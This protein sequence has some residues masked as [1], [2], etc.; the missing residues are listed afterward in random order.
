[1]TI[2]FSKTS[3]LYAGLLAITT[4]GSHAADHAAKA[5][6][7]HN[8]HG[9]KH[10]SYS[11]EGAPAQWGY[12]EPGFS[13]CRLGKQQSPVDIRVQGSGKPAPIDFAYTASSAEVVNNGHTVQI[14]LPDAGGFK[15]DGTEFKLAQFHFHTPSEEKI[16]GVA[17][18]MV[19]HLVHKSAAGNLA[20]VAVLF[21]L[22]DENQALK[23][24]FAKLPANG[25]TAHLSKAFNVSDLLPAYKGYYKFMGSLTTP[26]CTENVQWQ[27]LKQRV[28]IS[29]AQWEAF[30]K[31]YKMN[32][33][34]VQPLNQRQVEES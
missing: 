26:P 33:R 23:E 30:R 11:G 34:P 24:M 29:K 14:N 5:I 25:Q 6:D 16:R 22:G 32:A 3:L 1:M 12:L 27:I 8:A 10:W 4:L 19:A 15:L 2:C 7:Q 9:A 17:Y 13:L 31:L 28:E 18:P 20:V 21:E